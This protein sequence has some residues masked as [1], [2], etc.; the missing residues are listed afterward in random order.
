VRAVQPHLRKCFDNLDKLEFGGEETSVD[1]FAMFSSEGERVLLGNWSLNII[2]CL[3]SYG[4]RDCV[5]IWDDI[6]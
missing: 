6:E 1:I 2:C 3:F 4:N 5:L